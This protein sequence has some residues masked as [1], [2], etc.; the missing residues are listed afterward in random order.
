MKIVNISDTHGCHRELE[1]PKGDM[2]LHAGDI[3]NRG[4]K[5][6]VEDFINWFDALNFKYKIFIRGN[7]DWNL[8]NDCSLIPKKLPDSIIYL[9]NTSCHIEGIHI[10]GCPYQSEDTLQNW[11]HIPNDTDIIIS[12][13]PPFHIQDKA[14][15]G[16]HRGS[17]SLREKVFQVRPRLH[18]FGHI[19]VSYGFQKIND[20]TFINPSNYQASL[21]MIRRDPI[22]FDYNTSS[23]SNCSLKTI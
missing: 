21:D 5:E 1:L 2:L 15:N 14:P 17:V 11:E 13:N 10:F 4:N 3:C 20:I 6:H 23:I 22:I 7:H 8:E 16:L 9:D 19:H 18:M 12:H